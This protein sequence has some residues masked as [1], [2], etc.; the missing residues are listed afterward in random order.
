M[1]H[2]TDF[3]ASSTEASIGRLTVNEQAIWAS[4]AQDQPLE[5]RPGEDVNDLTFRSF[6]RA[7]AAL[8]LLGGQDAWWAADLAELEPAF[9]HTSK[10]ALQADPEWAENESLLRAKLNSPDGSYLD[11]LPFL[12]SAYEGLLSSDLSAI[13]ALEALM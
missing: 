1:F 5:L 2:S 7:T 11:I 4:L 12:H 8:T 9:V 10:L 13:S 6:I 3:H